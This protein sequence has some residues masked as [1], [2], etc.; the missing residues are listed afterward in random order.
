MLGQW[1]EAILCAL[2]NGELRFAGSVEDGG[3]GEMPLSECELNLNVSEPMSNK[4][5]LKSSRKG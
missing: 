3:S 4:H 1:G 2:S 5:Q